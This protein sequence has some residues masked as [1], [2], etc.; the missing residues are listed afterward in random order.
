VFGIR[1]QDQAVAVKPNE[2][3]SF[4]SMTSTEFILNKCNLD[5]GSFLVRDNTTN[6]VLAESHNVTCGDVVNRWTATG[7][8]NQIV[9]TESHP[10]E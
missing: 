2:I 3:A 5:S 6:K 10:K 1:L 7:K 8:G 4:S 9:C